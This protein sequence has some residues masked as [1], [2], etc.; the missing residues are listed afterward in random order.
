MPLD[1]FIEARILRP[2]RMESTGFYVKHDKLNRLVEGMK[3]PKTGKAQPLIDVTKPPKIL[4]GGGGMVASTMDYAR[5]AQMLLNRSRLDGVRIVTRKTVE[6]MTADHLGATIS[7]GALTGSGYSF[8][9]GFGIRM[10]NGI[11]PRIGTSGDYYWSGLAG[12][13]FWIDPKE[14][15]IAILMIQDLVRGPS[16]YYFPI[17]RSL[18]Y[19]AITE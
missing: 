15:L 18:V 6:Y 11:S 14:E 17:M 4:S 2:L 7:P 8:G 13:Y 5:F 9:L 10:Q 12:T 1:R 16:F 3:D 19:Q